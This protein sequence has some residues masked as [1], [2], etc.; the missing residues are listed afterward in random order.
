[1]Y[2][3]DTLF[4]CPYRSCSIAATDNMHFFF[5]STQTNAHSF[6]SRYNFFDQQP[7]ARGT[8]IDINWAI[9]RLLICDMSKTFV[10]TAYL[11]QFS[12]LDQC[13]VTKQIKLP[14]IKWLQCVQARFNH[15]VRSHKPRLC[16][17]LHYMQYT[18]SPCSGAT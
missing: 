14:S 4:P 12:I 6:Q 11:V 7:R 18:Q 5:H 1:M 3:Q 15:S 10:Q 17:T 16:K 8:A 9:K 13:R 2:L